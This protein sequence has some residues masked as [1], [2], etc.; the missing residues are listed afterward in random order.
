MSLVLF[1][2]KV[3]SSAAREVDL[4]D[5]C[6]V[7]GVVGLLQPIRGRERVRELLG[8][9]LSNRATCEHLDCPRSPHVLDLPFLIG[10]ENGGP[11]FTKISAQLVL[12]V[13]HRYPCASATVIATML[14]H[15]TWPPQGRRS[16]GA[17]DWRGIEQ[18]DLLC[19]K[20]IEIGV[21][22]SFGPPRECGNS[23]LARFCAINSEI[24]AAVVVAPLS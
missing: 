16:A 1:S 10:S 6:H 3:P 23:S 22:E 7:R 9:L 13:W 4:S 19:L 12:G 15:L 17:K 18:L 5:L 8:Y 2:Q 20:L 11:D 24:A 14:S 21:K